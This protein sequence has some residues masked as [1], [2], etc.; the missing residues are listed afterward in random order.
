MLYSTY[1]ISHLFRGDNFRKMFAEI[2]T[3]RSLIRKNVNI[4]TLT[5]TATHETAKSIF[6]Q[7][8]MAEAS[9]IGL[10]PRGLT[11]SIQSSQCA[12]WLIFAQY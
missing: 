11:S 8:S 7:L 4:L 2:G 5:A 3:I 12:V 10:P 9:K 1:C 6:E